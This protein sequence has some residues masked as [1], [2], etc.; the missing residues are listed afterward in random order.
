MK[1]AFTSG[2]EKIQ[3]YAVLEEELPIEPMRGKAI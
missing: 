1:E 3:V 2:C